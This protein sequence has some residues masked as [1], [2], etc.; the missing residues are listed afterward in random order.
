MLTAQTI[1]PLLV[2]EKT[3]A[4]MLS[5][6]VASLRADRFGDRQIP[7][8]KLGRRVRYPVASIVAFASGAVE[9]KPQS[10]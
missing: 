8:I 6:T 10:R 7:T 2:D 5:V 1:T 3:A 9:L 4:A